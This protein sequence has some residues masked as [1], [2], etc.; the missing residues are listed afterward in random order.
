MPLKLTKEEEALANSCTQRQK[1]MVLMIFE[2]PQL[3]HR[4]CYIRAGGKAKK[5]DAQDACVSRMLKNA[6]CKAFYDSLMNKA[7]SNAVLTKQEALERLS[8]SAKVTIK[9]VADFRN[10]RIGED[11]DG[12][13]VYQTVWTIKNAEDMPDHV[14][15]CIKSVTV[16]KDGPKVELYDGHA[17]IKQLMDMLGWEAPK[18]TQN[19]E[20]THEEWL[21]SLD[22]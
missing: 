18:K 5:A 8:R 17:A 9:D 7:Q 2:N 6:K 13:P 16:T 10:V 20:L 21:A 15:A 14:A 22:E 12:N 19:V 1:K 4:E 11:K 3:T